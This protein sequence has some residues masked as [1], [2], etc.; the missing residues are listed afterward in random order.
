MPAARTRGWRP[1]R[2]SRI[3][4]QRDHPTCRLGIAAYWLVI[5]LSPRGALA[6]SPHQP[7]ALYCAIVST[8]P[9]L[10]SSSRGGQVGISVKPTSPSSVEF[11]SQTRAARY[12]ADLRRNIHMRTA[13]VT[14]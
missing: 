13:G 11:I 4:H 3:P 9:W 1:C 14:R 12:A 8:K 2:H 10:A 6:P 5:P 7:Y